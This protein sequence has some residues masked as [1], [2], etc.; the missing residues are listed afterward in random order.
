MLPM[1]GACTICTGT[2]G[3]GAA[4]GMEIITAEPK[5]TLRALHRGR[6]V[7]RVGAVITSTFVIAV[8]HTA[9]SI[10]LPTDSSTLAFGWSS[11]INSRTH[12]AL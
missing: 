1:P 10:I 7:L 6:I 4:I 12:P 9:T 3:N 5:P 11:R 8:L 2:F